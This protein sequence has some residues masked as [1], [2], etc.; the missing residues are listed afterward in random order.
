M[1]ESISQS[2][3]NAMDWPREIWMA[4]RD[5]N[6]QG[7][8]RAVLSEHATVARWEGDEERDCAFHRYVDADIYESAERYHAGR[9]E[10]LLVERDEAWNAALNEAQRAVVSADPQED[11][12]PRDPAMRDNPYLKAWRAIEALKARP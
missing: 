12:D 8:V 6:D 7:V 10:A 11:R 9:R 1:S 2:V 4:E 5:E 3:T